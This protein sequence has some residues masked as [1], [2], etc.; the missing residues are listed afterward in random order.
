[1]GNWRRIVSKRRP[2]DTSLVIYSFCKMKYFFK[3]KL[4]VTIFKKYYL[5]E[6]AAQTN[7]H[8]ILSPTTCSF[9]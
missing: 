3:L 4:I 5:C 1:M 9:N 7:S 2:E 8:S 6:V